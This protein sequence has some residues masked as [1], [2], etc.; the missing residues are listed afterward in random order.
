MSR[1]LTRPTSSDRGL[2]PLPLRAS[3]AG[4]YHKLRATRWVIK[5]ICA[6]RIWLIASNGRIP[7]G[8]SWTTFRV[9]PF[10]NG[11]S[12]WC[13]GATVM[14]PREKKRMKKNFFP[15]S[16][17]VWKSKSRDDA[18]GFVLFVSSLRRRA[19][20]E[21]SER[22]VQTVESS[23]A[24]VVGVCRQLWRDEPQPRPENSIISCRICAFFLFCRRRMLLRRTAH[25]VINADLEISVGFA[26]S[27]EEKET[28]CNHTKVVCFHL[29]VSVRLSG[30]LSAGDALRRRIETSAG[31]RYDMVVRAKD[32]FD[33]II[34]V[35]NDTHMF[36][37]VA[38]LP[39]AFSL[40]CCAVRWWI[41]HASVNIPDIPSHKL[42]KLRFVWILLNFIFGCVTASSFFVTY[43]AW[44]IEER[45]KM[46]YFLFLWKSLIISALYARWMH[47]S[48]NAAAAEVDDETCESNIHSKMRTK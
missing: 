44:M 27:Q 6:E 21:W 20:D 28:V 17:Q 33:G 9:A 35:I 34:H 37:C 3:D 39:N 11:L 2:D 31:G 4:T 26:V 48:V 10:G 12:K 13:T 22:L 42:M 15:A 1:V 18:C 47:T 7:D 24:P 8:N 38:V 40:L 16:D 23:A 41:L 30:L 25:K 19:E 5:I 29:I 46:N 36:C 14:P 32:S 45:S 43:S